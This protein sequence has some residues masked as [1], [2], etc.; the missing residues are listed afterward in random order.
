MFT[1]YLFE[2]S[3]GVVDFSAGVVRALGDWE[4]RVTVTTPKDIGT[5]T[6]EIFV[7]EPPL[8]NT[9]VFVAGDTLSYRELHQLLEE[10]TGE[11]FR[12][13]LLDQAALQDFV[14]KNPEDTAG[15]YRLAFARPDGV[16]W[17]LARTFNGT[18]GI[19]T[20]TAREWLV[21]HLRHKAHF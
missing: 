8:N 11:T 7:A 21:E 15:K 20:E 3:F 4:H 19:K 13:E 17:D 5:L 16:A 9:V 10:C 14:E 12:A 6:A 18:R 2:P 1:S